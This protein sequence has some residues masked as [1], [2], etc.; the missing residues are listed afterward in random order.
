[1]V[2]Q[3]FAWR[4]SD[5]QIECFEGQAFF[6]EG[7][8]FELLAH[9]TTMV[10]QGL[11]MLPQLMSFTLSALA[12]LLLCEEA[13]PPHLNLSFIALKLFQ[14]NDLGPIGFCPAPF[15]PITSSRLIS[16]RF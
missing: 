8:R 4:P 14:V 10:N 16:W 5:V 1:L 3:W 11:A 2:P 12:R 13:L 6:L 15:L 9:P 7:K